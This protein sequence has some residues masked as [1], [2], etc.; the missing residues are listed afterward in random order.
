MIKKLTVLFLCL[1]A[2][3]TQSLAAT[4]AP[5]IHA[6][7]VNA[8]IQKFIDENHLPGVIVELYVDGK[9]ESYYFG[10]ANPNLQTPMNPN[11]IFEVGSL[12]KV[13]T[14]IVLAQ[15]IDAAKMQLDAPVKKYLPALSDDFAEITLKNL[16]THTSGL[17]F[18]LSDEM[19]NK[20]KTRKEL[21][22]YLA[23]FYPDDVVDDQWAYSNFGI[24][25]LGFALENVT[26]KPLDELVRQQL[27]IPLGMQP[28][29]CTV[30]P[31][32]QKNYAAGFDKDGNAVPPMPL[33]LFAAAGHYKASATDMQHF[34]S[35]AI[36]LPG[37]PERILYPM[38]MT[39]AV[40]VEL[41][42]KM[43]G[44]GWDIHPLDPEYIHPLLSDDEKLL[45][46]KEIVEIYK[47][48]I[49]SGDMLIDKT[50]G[51]DGFRT[52]IA[53][54]PNKQ[55]GIVILTNKFVPGGAIARTGR[56]ILFKLNHIH[57]DENA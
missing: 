27:L 1:I 16:A 49:Y 15:E 24:G 11:T 47:K 50:G 56:D 44:L 45:D 33:G 31:A 21:N 25:V 5:A 3:I 26:H 57:A 39:Q 6:D 52:Y 13:M 12:S 46:P 10:Y 35:A 38:R 30:P 2:G 7:I 36:G 14:S 48:P 4:P 42:T 43:Q 40:Y 28:I 8:A 18:S 29:A 17:P 41:P 9:P 22:Q 23:T 51:T 55:S 32:L 19:K 34:L 37:T 54:I 20:I 53:V